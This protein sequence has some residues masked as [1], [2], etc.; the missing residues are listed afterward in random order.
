MS[1]LLPTSTEIYINNY[2]LAISRRQHYTLLPVHYDFASNFMNN[3]WNKNLAI[4]NRS[5]VSCTHNTLKVS[6]ITPWPWNL[7]KGSLKVTGPWPVFSYPGISGFGY[8]SPGILANVH[9]HYFYRSTM[10]Y[11]AKYWP[12]I[13]A[14]NAGYRLSIMYTQND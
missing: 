8:P 2:Y 11:W 6:T 10:C 9:L 7:D 1:Q 3:Y 12:T 13:V 14:I 4:A 5:H